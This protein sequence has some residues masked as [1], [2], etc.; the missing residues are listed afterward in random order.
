MGEVS[1]PA[2]VERVIDADTVEVTLQVKFHVRI[3]DCWAAEKNTPEGREAIKFA[4]TLVKRGDNVVVNLP[5][6]KSGLPAI[7][8]NRVVGSI[9]TADGLDFGAT[10]VNSGH[11]TKS[12]P[13]VVGTSFAK[14]TDLDDHL[15]GHFGDSLDGSGS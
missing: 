11:A 15:Y 9:I 4:S 12:K 10:L 14:Q 5:L 3:L 7:S 6:A 8:F 2:T 13:K 1:V